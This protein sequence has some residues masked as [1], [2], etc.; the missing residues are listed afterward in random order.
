MQAFT[1]LSG[2]CFCFPAV[3]QQLPQRLR[4]QKQLLNSMP[5]SL[6]DILCV[7]FYMFIVLQVATKVLAHKWDCHAVRARSSLHAVDGSI[8]HALVTGPYDREG[9]RRSMLQILAPKR[10][11]L[12]Q[13]HNEIL[14]RRSPLGLRRLGVSLVLSLMLR[15]GRPLQITEILICVTGL[16]NASPIS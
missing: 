16:G 14:S 3:L 10:E 12:D 15:P 11:W 7:G 5:G 2:A 4:R 6:F 8:H 9:D 13:A 1:W